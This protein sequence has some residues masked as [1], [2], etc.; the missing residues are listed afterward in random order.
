[1]KD[2]LQGQCENVRRFQPTA[3]NTRQLRD[4]FGQFATGVTVVS[5]K[6]DDGVIGMTANSFSSLSLDPALVMWSP[7]KQSKRF[8]FFAHAPHFAIHVLSDEQQD[9]CAAFAQNGFAFDDIDHTLNSHGVPLI[10]GCLAR[11]ECNHL[12][13]HPAGDH[14]IVIGRVESIETQ[15]GTPLAFYAGE[16]RSLANV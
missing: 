2:L 12:A 11:F 16:F 6:T 7:A 1:M 8:G 3:S 14:V 15:A 13:T 9:I 10:K 5:T 4:A